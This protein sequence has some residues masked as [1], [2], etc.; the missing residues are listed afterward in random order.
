[1][2]EKNPTREEQVLLGWL[3]EAAGPSSPSDLLARPRPQGVSSL[4]LRS[5][6]VRLVDRGTAKFTPE[7]KIELTER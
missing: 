6:L 1:M 7:R 4:G 3:K 5:A 2:T